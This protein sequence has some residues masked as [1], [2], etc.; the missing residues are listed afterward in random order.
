MDSIPQEILEEVIRTKILYFNLKP[1]SNKYVDMMRQGGHDVVTT[2]RS[3]HALAMM[4]RQSF[5][6]LVMDC[7]QDTVDILNFTAKAHGF[8]RR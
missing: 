4:H 7:A 5:D 3:A 2:S 6:A 8:N 1:V